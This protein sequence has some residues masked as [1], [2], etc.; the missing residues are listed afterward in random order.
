MKSTEEHNIDPFEAALELG[1][2][3]GRSPW[4]DAWHRLLKNKA[5]VVSA[6][7]MAFMMLLVIVGPWV[8]SWE[9]DFTDWDHTSS[10]PSLADGHWFGTDAVG[11]DI[12]VRTLEGGRISLGSSASRRP[13]PI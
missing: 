4:E 3:K 5:A 9:A 11:R 8:I 7:I 1:D 10:P 13:S 2:V 6:L 12:L